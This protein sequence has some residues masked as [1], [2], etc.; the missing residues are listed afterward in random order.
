MKI[1]RSIVIALSA[2]I[3]F[4]ATFLGLSIY[5]PSPPE[6]WTS[7]Q[8]GTTRD[9]VL[10]SGVVDPS[11]YIPIKYLDQQV[12]RSDHSIYGRTTHYLHVGYN[13]QFKVDSVGIECE[14]ERFRFW[15][16]RAIFP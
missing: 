10:A 1:T 4:G 11:Y 8:I 3:F 2:V 14:T 5:I 13:E 15:R 16:R 12:S 7:I 9:E 6:G